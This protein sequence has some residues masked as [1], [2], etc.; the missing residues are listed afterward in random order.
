MRDA[1]QGLAVKVQSAL[2]K[3]VDEGVLK[4]GGDEALKLL[5]EGRRLTALKYDVFGSAQAREAI[6]AATKKP[7]TT[8][9]GQADAN[10]GRIDSLVR[11]IGPQNARVISGQ[12]MEDISR[13][14]NQDGK[15]SQE[16]FAKAWDRMGPETKRKLFPDDWKELESLARTS[17]ENVSK[18]KAIKAPTPV[19]A[20]FAKPD[21]IDEKPSKVGMLMAAGSLLSKLFIP[22]R[23]FYLSPADVRSVMASKGGSEAINT[24]LTSTSYEKARGAIARIAAI[25]S[26]GAQRSTE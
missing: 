15:F 22:G 26:S 25:G 17:I 23:G 2:R 3:S 7:M 6:R 20:E 19:A 11:Q 16:A 18:P 4:S 1:A 21:L 8:V 14:A 24:L 5:N 9:V 12:V 13:V 10:L